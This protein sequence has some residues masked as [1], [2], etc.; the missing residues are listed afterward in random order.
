M[1]KI[2]D[3]AIT[4]YDFFSKLSTQQNVISN[5]QLCLVEHSLKK[6][7]DDLLGKISYKLCFELS[8]SINFVSKLIYRVY[9]I[10]VI[11]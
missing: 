11:E 8:L 1:H 6:L 7:S 5:L 4:L 3:Y 2:K 10:G 9:Y